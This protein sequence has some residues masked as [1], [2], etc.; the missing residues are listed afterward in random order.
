MTVS[1]EIL[2]HEAAHA[3]AIFRADDLSLT[4]IAFSGAMPMA[5]HKRNRLPQTL[6]EWL[7]YAEQEMLVSL[8]GGLEETRKHYEVYEQDMRENAMRK[9]C[10]FPE[11]WWQKTYVNDLALSD[12][13]NI[14][15]HIGR[16]LAKEWMTPDKAQ[17]LYEQK[18]DEARSFIEDTA[19]RRAIDAL[20]AKMQGQDDLSGAEAIAVIEVSDKVGR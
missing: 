11:R 4:S 14:V 20:V 1:D 9:H 13:G 19:N 3:V 2:H 16:F 5:K 6:D 17:S 10:M 18:L 7:S 8:V 15:E 12:W